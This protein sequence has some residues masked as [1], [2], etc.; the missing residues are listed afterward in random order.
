MK[1]KSM[2]K[3]GFTLIELLV[4][5]AIIAILASLILPA[6]S[7][8]K[9]KGQQAFCINNVKQVSLAFLGYSIENR[10]T[11]PSGA[12][13]LP[14]LPV[15]ED[16][17]YW[18]TGDSR[19]T[20]PNRKDVNKSPLAAHIG[21]FNT[22]LFRCPSDKDVLKRIPLLGQLTYQFSY[23]ANSMMEVIGMGGVNHG[24]CSLYA[25]DPQFETLHFKI[26]MLKN[27]GTKLMIVEE[28]AYSPGGAL[29][30]ELPDDGRWTPGTD[31]ASIG[32]NH[33][34]PYPSPPSYVSNRHNK[35]GVVSFGDG[36]VEAVKPSFGAMPEHFDCLY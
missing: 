23:T 18:N 8:A 20:N 6:L 5:I 22:N 32:L 25:G 16:W 12:A 19:I 2:M 27:P 7:K 10:D 14:T 35:R 11:F 34:P 36:H 9:A 29:V 28:H 15:D 33:P 31:P 1:T 4:V 17:I 3:A 30:G 24:I 26:S 13:K 21:N